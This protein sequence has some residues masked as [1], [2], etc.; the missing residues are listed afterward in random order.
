MIVSE[1][2]MPGRLATLIVP[3]ADVPVEAAIH[4]AARKNGGKGYDDQMDAN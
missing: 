4:D 2:F 1:L 3:D